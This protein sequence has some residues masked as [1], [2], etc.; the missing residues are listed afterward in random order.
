[1]TL[2][3]S[4]GAYLCRFRDVSGK[5]E[6]MAV[7]LDK[8]LEENREEICAQI[9]AQRSGEMATYRALPVEDVALGR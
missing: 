4:R 1:M 8:V 3:R 9:M 2:L 7:E 6:E 5:G